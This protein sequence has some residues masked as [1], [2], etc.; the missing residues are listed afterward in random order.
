VGY[1]Q[2]LL[3][4]AIKV[5]HGTIPLYLTTLYS[6]VN[7]SSFEA[8]SIKGVVMEEMLHM[9][10]AANVLNAIGGAPFIDRPDFVPTYPLI[11][12]LINVTASIAWF[13]RETTAHYQMLESVP[14][15]GGWNASISAAYM[16][17]TGCMTALCQQHGEAAVFTGNHSLQVESRTSN[18]EFAGKVLSLHD[19]TLALMGVS[20]QGG[21]C[22]VEGHPFPEFVNIS[23]G[24]LGGQFSHAARFTEI[25]EGR[26]YWW[27]DTVG[28]PTGPERSVSW[29]TA[30]KFTPNPTVSDFAPE[31]C[32]QG[33]PWLVRNESFFVYDLW[34]EHNQSLSSSITST[35]QECAD[36][37]IQWTLANDKPLMPCAMWSW[38]SRDN[39][40]R[41]DVPA[42]EC[43]LGQ[44]F[45]PPT[46]GYSGGFISG[47]LYGTVCNNGSLPHNVPPADEPA[48]SVPAAP[49]SSLAQNCS[50]AHR[51]GEEF[52]GNYTAFLVALHDVFNG[53]PE[54]LMGTVGQMYTLK[55]MA[56][57]MMEMDD[58]RITSWRDTRSTAGPLLNPQAGPRAGP[59][60][61]SLGIGPPWEYMPAASRFEA[62]G[63]RA[64]PGHPPMPELD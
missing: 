46:T 12:P 26:Q 50:R 10:Q 32:V 40:T 60:K 39:G 15:P 1:V 21:G 47:C 20:D 24:P 6:I 64:R 29:D 19:A 41:A 22:P 11:L 63:R 25:L 34:M 45:G 62:R 14:D 57:E 28:R 13:N 37:C 42:N 49:N 5:E 43:L 61:K 18:G 51:K 9:V 30:R 54:L 44:I 52:A 8:V 55:A 16:H 4:E 59:A 27:N 58:P 23:S 33:G 53:Q 56:I 36:K 31:Q 2:D 48:P 35:W 38:Q 7:Q 3:Q 17:I